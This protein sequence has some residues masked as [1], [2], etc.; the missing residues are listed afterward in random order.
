MIESRP[1][2]AE[3]RGDGAPGAEHEADASPGRLRRWSIPFLV[4]AIVFATHVCSGVTTS[5]DSRWS[6]YTALSLIHH[7]DTTLDDYPEVIAREQGYAIERVGSHVY[8]IY[9]V[10]ASLVAIPFVIVIEQYYRL[11]LGQDL[12]QRMRQER[13][14]HARLERLI[15]SVLVALTAVLVYDIG[16]MVMGS[17]WR[18]LLLALVFAFGTSAWSTASRAMWQH[19]PSMLCL[20]LALRMLLE[21]GVRPNR[22]PLA[23]LALAF[24]YV[25]RPTNALSLVGLS[26]FVVQRH[27]AW[28]WRWLGAVALVLVPFAVLNWT[29]YAAPL[30]PYYRGA[31][32]FGVGGLLEAMAGNLVSPARGLFVFSPVLAFAVLGIAVRLRARDRREL[33]G[34]LLAI[35]V[36][37]WVVVSSLR[38]W[39]AGDSFGPRFLSDMLPYLAYFLAPV[40]SRLS[41]DA[42][43]GRRALTAAFA[44]SLL[45]SVLIHGRA[46]I[47]RDGYAWNGDPIQVDRVPGRLWDWRDPPFLRGLV[48]PV[49][50]NPRSDSSIQSP[51]SFG[52]R[53]E[54]MLADLVAPV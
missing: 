21:A 46:A 20:A 13:N 29:I 2:I 42:G 30:S 44:T 39:W 10:G 50:R 16:L 27:R 28:V 40:L 6:L 34:W 41:W 53:W 17:P 15:A 45:L 48:A 8:S 23:G 3:T 14:L 4:F 25:V 35:L 43:V 26:A 36:A 18:A 33:D 12:D 5:F 52:I 11:I 31:H 19:G 47:S 38:P 32:T 49:R 1:L 37:H 22:L 7:G 9:P 54:A 24:A 51:A